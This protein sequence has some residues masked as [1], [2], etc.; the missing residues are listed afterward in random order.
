MPTLT[1]ACTQWDISVL[2]AVNVGT[3]YKQLEVSM[4]ASS[5]ISTSKTQK[6]HFK[7]ICPSIQVKAFLPAP[8]KH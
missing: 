5:K 1:E 6:A 7:L 4:M 3:L 2:A 8:V